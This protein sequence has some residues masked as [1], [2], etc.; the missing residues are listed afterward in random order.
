LP[1][2]TKDDVNVE[3]TDDAIN[4]SGERRNEDEE[5]REGYYRSER[6][7]G[8]FF[9]SIQLPEG[10]N[11][12]DANATFNNGVLEITMEAPQLQSRGRRLEI[13]EGAASDEQARGKAAGRYSQLLQITQAVQLNRRSRDAGTQDTLQDSSVTLLSAIILTFLSSV[14]P[15]P[16]NL[17]ISVI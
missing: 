11:A 3:I 8:G 12:E 6:S 5:R 4:I 14:L 1:G 7:Y 2:L 16:K 15:R 17:A 10:A 9:R 13:K